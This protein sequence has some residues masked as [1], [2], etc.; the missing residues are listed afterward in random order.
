[1]T[2]PKPTGRALFAAVAPRL[3]RAHRE[4]RAE[5]DRL[6]RELALARDILHQATWRLEHRELELIRTE[7][8]SHSKRRLEKRAT[9]LDTAKVQYDAAV[10]HVLEA[11]KRL[12][13]A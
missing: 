10:R 7:A 3:E 9:K 6:R 1:M 5:R 8:W 2:R 11:E 13:A 12:R 4:R